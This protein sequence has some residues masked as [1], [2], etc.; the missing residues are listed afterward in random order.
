MDGSLYG[1][2]VSLLKGD[3]KWK[4]K[5]FSFILQRHYIILV[6]VYLANKFFFLISIKE[7]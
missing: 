6:Y 3:T 2:L 5:V 1:S 7:A 4:L